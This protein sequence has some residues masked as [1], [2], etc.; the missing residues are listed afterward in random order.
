MCSGP[1]MKASWIASVA[2]TA[3][4]GITPLVSPLAQVIMSGI[5]PYFSAPHAVPVRP[6]PVITSSKIRRMPCLV[7][8]S[9]SRSRYPFGGISTP[10]EPATGSTITAAIVEASCSATIRSSSSASSAP[11]SGWPLAKA[12][13]AGRWV[14]GRWS[15][16]VSSVPKYLRL[17]TIPP[18]E[19]PPKFTP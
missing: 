16:P 7:Q 4:I 14:C 6:N 1:V 3:P 19:M 13:F 12:F 10:V 17:L 5:T 15:T 2:S 9:R 18:T 11:C 8:I